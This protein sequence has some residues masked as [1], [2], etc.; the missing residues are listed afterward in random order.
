VF[1]LANQGPQHIADV[2]HDLYDE[3]VQDLFHQRPNKVLDAA[4]APSTLAAL[5][6]QLAPSIPPLPPAAAEAAGTNGADAPSSAVDSAQTFMLAQW[7][8]V[9]RFAI[10]QQA[11]NDEELYAVPVAAAVGWIRMRDFV[12]WFIATNPSLPA[13]ADG[14]G[15]D[16]PAAIES[17]ALAQRNY[18]SLRPIV[19][20]DDLLRLLCADS[21]S[22][23][24]APAA[25]A[26]NAELAEPTAVGVDA[27]IVARKMVYEDFV[28]A[29]VR[30]WSR[31]DKDF[32][33]VV[34]PLF[35]AAAATAA[36][37]GGTAGIDGGGEGKM[38]SSPTGLSEGFID[39]AGGWL[40]VGSSVSSSVLSNQLLHRLLLWLLSRRPLDN[41]SSSSS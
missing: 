15:A 35:A 5:Y 10:E 27:T 2:V 36:A 20:Q 41:A 13:A 19:T 16:D 38:E 4:F 9:K 32:I 40:D 12:A 22:L 23:P 37:A 8:A 14:S 17:A 31:S 11:L 28:E 26:E 18:V 6:P 39:G 29:L 3:T 34:N 30:I 33:R 21:Q 7:E 1:P 24:T 25:A